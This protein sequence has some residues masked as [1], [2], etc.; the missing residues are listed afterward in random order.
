M[1]RKRGLAKLVAGFAAAFADLD[2]ARAAGEDAEH[3]QAEAQALA[4]GRGAS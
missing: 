2:A 4:M 3:G 1:A